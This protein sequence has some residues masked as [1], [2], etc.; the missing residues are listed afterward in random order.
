[1]NC[2][3]PKNSNRCSLSSL[4]SCSLIR[5]HRQAVGGLSWPRVPSC[6]PSGLSTD[7]QAA[8]GRWDRRGLERA[9]GAHP[10]PNTP[11]TQPAPRKRRGRNKR[12]LDKGWDPDERGKERGLPSLQGEN[13]SKLVHLPFDEKSGRRALWPSP[14]WGCGKTLWEEHGGPEG[15]G[16]SNKRVGT[17]GDGEI[18][19]LRRWLKPG[20]TRESP[21]P[22]PPLMFA[23]A[24]VLGDSSVAKPL[25]GAASPGNPNYRPWR[26]GCA[27]G[28]ELS[29]AP[30]STSPVFHCST[31][32]HHPEAPEMLQ[33]NY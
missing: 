26:D 25:I 9:V 22:P 3:K 11:S 29:C 8:R 24:G 2:P 31:E 30:P 6:R 15:R 13:G 28:G 1:M 18:K 23:L 20:Y 10:L 19:Q 7:P 32:G 21:P 17:S 12:D 5:G 27:C 16:V 4:K 33:P 14:R